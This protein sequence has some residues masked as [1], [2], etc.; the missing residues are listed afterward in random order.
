MFGK[1]GLR[2]GSAQASGLNQPKNSRDEMDNKRNYQI[3]HEQSYRTTSSR[4]FRTNLEFAR[5][6]AHAPEDRPGIAQFSEGRSTESI[7]RKS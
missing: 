3:V 2:N 6:R 4:Q 5:D 1:N 7:T